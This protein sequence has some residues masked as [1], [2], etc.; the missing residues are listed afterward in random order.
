MTA[1]ETLRLALAATTTAIRQELAAILDPSA[2]ADVERELAVADALGREH[3]RQLA[4]VKAELASAR[5]REYA[6]RGERDQALARAEAAT[7]RFREQAEA[8]LARVK[9]ELTA[10][11]PWSDEAVR[12]ATHA[13]AAEA[14]R[15]GS[16]ETDWVVGSTQFE[17]SGVILRA[18]LATLAPPPAAQSAEPVKPG[19]GVVRV[20]VAD[21]DDV[22][23]AHVHHGPS[24]WGGSAD[25]GIV[26]GTRYILAADLDAI[27]ATLLAPKKAV[28]RG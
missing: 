5:A 13:A 3:E 26:P 4:A 17:V 8:E 15:L 2:H 28:R 22:G 12:R 27:A 11:F 19:E 1:I 23:G 16:E 20:R 21:T 7:L 10:P 24:G 18:A 9:A 6:A 25:G 14:E